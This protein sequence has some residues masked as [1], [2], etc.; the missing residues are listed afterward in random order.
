MD[1]Q[2]AVRVGGLQDRDG[3]TQRQRE[4]RERTGPRTDAG[5][6]GKVGL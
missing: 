3:E 5:G 2:L 4:F 1:C 6:V